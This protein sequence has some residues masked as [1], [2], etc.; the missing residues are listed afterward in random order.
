MFGKIHNAVYFSRMTRN[1]ASMAAAATAK[2]ACRGKLGRT[3]AVST[4]A[5]AAFAGR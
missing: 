3:A 2:T 4:L 5:W 1:F